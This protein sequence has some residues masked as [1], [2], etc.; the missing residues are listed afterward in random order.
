MYELKGYKILL[1]SYGN[2]IGERKNEKEE[3]KNEDL[4]KIIAKLQTSK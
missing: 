3:V 2:Q 1:Q 4:D